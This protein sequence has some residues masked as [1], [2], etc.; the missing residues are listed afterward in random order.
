MLAGIKNFFKRIGRALVLFLNPMWRTIWIALAGQ[1]IFLVSVITMSPLRMWETPVVN[2]NLFYVPILAAILGPLFYRCCIEEQEAKGY[3]YGFFAALF[4]WPLIGEVANIP[5]DKGV[6]TQISDFNIKGLGGYFYVLAGWALLHVMWRTGALKKSVCVFFMT[7][8]S[9]WSFELYM[10]NYSSMDAD[11]FA[12]VGGLLVIAIVVMLL[13]CMKLA[14]HLF[15]LKKPFKAILGILVT[16]I[17]AGSALPNYRDV[18]GFVDPLQKMGP[19]GNLVLF[20][21]LIASILILRA[22]RKTESLE[23]KTI[24]GCI[25]YIVFA[26]ILMSGQWKEPQTFYVKYEAAHIGHEIESLKQDQ[27]N[28]E[29]LFDYMAT[30]RML[31]AGDFKYMYDHG[32]LPMA[33][34]KNLVNMGMVDGKG[35][36]FLTTRGLI[37]MDEF[38]AVL[39]R[40]MLSDAHMKPL[41]DMGIAK[42]NDKGIYE[43][44]RQY[45]KMEKKEG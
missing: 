11:T 35:L 14:L 21:S 23:R 26:L 10:D 6:I 28:L 18:I 16:L 8:L 1:G 36:E 32:I 13:F 33:K 20:G 19:M 30:K 9:I 25:F 29:R 43:L 44:M 41:V 22:S 5:V 39:D 15:K 40:R 4:A 17:V 24:L 2:Y 34:L 37:T 45:I 3:L 42:K 12:I 38:Q 27:A 31:K 7:F